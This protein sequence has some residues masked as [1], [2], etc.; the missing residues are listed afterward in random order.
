MGLSKFGRDE[1]L[2][3]YQQ[4]RE[5]IVDKIQDGTWLPDTAIPTEAELTKQ[6][7]VAIGTIRKAVDALVTDGLLYRS[8][9]RGTFVRRPDFNASLFRF[10]RQTSSDGKA[11]VPESK[12]LSR[13][14]GL[15]PE[16]AVK[17][18]NLKANDL[19]I[20]LERN[21]FLGNRV[22]LTEEIWLPESL[23]ASL[24]DIDFAEFGNLLYPFYE[25]QCGLLVAS[26]KET[27]T[28]EAAD[29]ATANTLGIDEGRPVAVIERIAYGYDKT[30]I[31]YR[32]SRGSAETFRYQIE[33]T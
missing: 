10:F 18:L 26:A 20:R 25:R 32:L 8:Q 6:Y 14:L 7:G 23:F 24:V 16:A 1:R 2:P 9:G 21:R 4:V 31:E 13:K 29:S 11:Q 27:L 33:I 15:P 3:L 22:V 30:P 5:E 12:I 17:A 28:I 19:A